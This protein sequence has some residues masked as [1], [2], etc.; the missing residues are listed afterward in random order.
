MLSLA[1]FSIR[2]R[3]VFFLFAL[4]FLVLA[5]PRENSSVTALTTMFWVGV[6]GSRARCCASLR[7]TRVGSEACRT[8]VVCCW[9]SHPSSPHPPCP[10]S[11]LLRSLCTP[12]NTSLITALSIGPSLLTKGPR[13]AFL[14]LL[15]VNLFPLL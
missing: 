14:P 7:C 10:L 5:W 8:G 12:A 3:L 6:S 11:A 9:E 1:L 2:I 15:L 4:F 13:S